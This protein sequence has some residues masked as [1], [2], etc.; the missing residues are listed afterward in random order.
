MSKLAENRGGHNRTFDPKINKGRS[1]KVKLKD[2]PWYVRAGTRYWT[3]RRIY[4]HLCEYYAEHEIV[5]SLAA[6]DVISRLADNHYMKSQALAAIKENPDSPKVGR[7]CAYGM[8]KS[9]G[10]QISDSLKV[11]GLYPLSK[12]T[13]EPKSEEGKP[14]DRPEPEKKSLKHKFKVYG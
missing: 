3:R 5:D 12:K 13:M 14:D 4:K 7:Q 1:R 9:S 2:W 6:N 8:L 11:L 10:V